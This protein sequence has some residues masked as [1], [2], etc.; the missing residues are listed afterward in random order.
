MGYDHNLNCYPHEK[1]NQCFFW[2]DW[3]GFSWSKIYYLIKCHFCTED[4]PSP[5]TSR[6]SCSLVTVETESKTNQDQGLLLHACIKYLFALFIIVKVQ[7]LVGWT[8]L[9]LSK[10]VKF[11]TQVDLEQRRRDLF[12]VVRKIKCI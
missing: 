12:V 11:K 1:L 5:L 8:R 4:T 3:V 9:R 7:S 10:S 2:Y 6:D